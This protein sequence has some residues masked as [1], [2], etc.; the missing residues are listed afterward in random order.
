MLLST[1]WWTRHVKTL[2][3]SPNSKGVDDK[4]EVQ[5][6]RT[7]KEGAVGHIGIFSWWD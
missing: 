4:S 2:R 7:F 3:L 1:R 6:A 5:R